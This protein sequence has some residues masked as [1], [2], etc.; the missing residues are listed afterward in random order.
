MHSL[1]SSNQM[2]HSTISLFADPATCGCAPCTNARI[3]RTPLVWGPGT[4]AGY[5]TPPRKD[6]SLSLPPPPPLTRTTASSTEKS[7]DQEENDVL[8]RLATLRTRLLA[9]QESLTLE[10]SQSHSD[11]ALT[12]MEWTEL[13]LKISAIETFF[14]A[15]RSIR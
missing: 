15:F 14:Q 7:L 8:D 10:S 4:G 13:D 11:M 3:P 2:A 12:D 5:Q 9:R 1:L 6:S